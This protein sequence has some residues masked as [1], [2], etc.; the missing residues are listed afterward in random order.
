[1]EFEVRLFAGET[2]VEQR[3]HTPWDGRLG[4]EYQP[5][6]IDDIAP[7]TENGQPV[8][9]P[10]DIFHDGQVTLLA[11]HPWREVFMGGTWGLYLDQ[12]TAHDEL[13]LMTDPVPAGTGC[14]AG[15]APADIEALVESIVSDSDLET[16]APVVVSLGGTQALSMEVVAAPGASVCDYWPAPLVLSS[17]EQTSAGM[18]LEPGDRMRLYLLDLPEGVSTRILAIALIA[19][20]ERFEPVVDAATPILE[21]IEFDA[22]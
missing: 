2:V 17:N 21:S 14:E 18:A 7:T 19:P 9:V 10:Y 22:G 16:T 13:L 20:E 3:L 4:L 8:A 12:G 6:R 1:M 11:P 5:T 15:P